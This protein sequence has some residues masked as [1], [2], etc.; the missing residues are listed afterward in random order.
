K[1]GYARSGNHDAIRICL[2]RR[3]LVDFD[4]TRR[5]IE[6]A[7]RICFLRGKPQNSLPVEYY[8]M[9]IA[10]LIVRHVVF[11][12][13]A[14]PRIELADVSLEVGCE[15][16]VPLRIGDKA[17]WTRIGSFERKFLNLP[18]SRIESSQLV[19]HL[20]RVPK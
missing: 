15:P 3:Y 7:H 14:G 5:W 20:S 16:D 4:L 18:R 13:F 1:I 2:W 10:G 12:Y 19:R 8:G 11:G 6:A 17:M 9:W